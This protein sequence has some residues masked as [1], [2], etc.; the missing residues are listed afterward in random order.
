M[1]VLFSMFKKLDK[2]IAEKQNHERWHTVWLR[3]RLPITVLLGWAIALVGLYGYLSHQLITPL[4]FSI[5]VL[6]FITTSAWG[7]FLCIL[8]YIIRPLLFF[9]ATILTILS[10]VF[11]GFWGGSSIATVGALISAGVAYGIGHA[12]G[13]IPKGLSITAVKPWRQFL[14]HHPFEAT[15]AMHLTFLPFDAVNY[16]SGLNRIGLMPFLGGVLFGI[17]PGVIS[18]VSIGASVD[19]ATL[20]HDGISINIVNPTLVWTSGTIFA[21]S[22]V[23]AHTIRHFRA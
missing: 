6:T 14:A 15:L 22:L 8:A 21:I 5:T 11:F 20:L 7:P 9:P 10:G 2:I 16:F 19:V 4:A 1:K 12:Y 23:V 17:M 18:F 13:P 3:Y